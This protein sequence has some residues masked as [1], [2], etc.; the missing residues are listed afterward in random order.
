MPT[1]IPGARLSSFDRGGHVVLAVER[2]AIR[3][4]VRAHVLTHTDVAA[5]EVP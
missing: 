3:A 4:A 2:D 1:T 5:A